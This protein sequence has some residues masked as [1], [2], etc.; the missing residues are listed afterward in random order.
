[1]SS[2]KSPAPT[3]K[4]LRS[5]L[6]DLNDSLDPITSQS[7]EK[8]TS[9]LE[10]GT[11]A[12]TS[13]NDVVLTGRL[14]SAQLQSSLA[15]ILLDLVWILL[16]VNGTDPTSH[17]VT[18]ELKRVQQYLEK[19]HKIDKNLI[20]A[21]FKNNQ[22]STSHSHHI[23]QAKASRFIKGAL[24]SNSGNPTTGKRTVFAEDGTIQKVVPVG[25]EEAEPETKDESRKGAE[26]GETEDKD[27][28]KWEE[29]KSKRRKS[30]KGD[31]KKSG[32]KS[33]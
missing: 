23:D 20:A 12:G 21:N 24:G 31:K 18:A 4:K 8:L 22:Q 3:I 19:V 17:P 28:G 9:N 33:K 25:S 15:Y 13:S 16:K 32:G 6:R 2:L 10:S 7:L 30:E 26:K 27:D 11:K 29:P 5:L 14:E 1:M